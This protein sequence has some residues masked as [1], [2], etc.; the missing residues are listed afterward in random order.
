MGGGQESRVLR[1]Q[2]GQDGVL[3]ARTAGRPCAGAVRGIQADG[4]SALGAGRLAEA[5]VIQTK[6]LLCRL[7]REGLMQRHAW[8]DHCAAPTRMRH[9]LPLQLGVGSLEIVDASRDLRR[10]AHP[11][12]SPAQAMVV[13]LEVGPNDEVS[14]VKTYFGITFRSR[15]VVL[16]TGTFMNGTI[17]VGR[18]SM[19]AGRCDTSPHWL[20]S[21]CKPSGCITARWERSDP[22]EGVEVWCLGSRGVV[23]GVVLRP[24]IG[25]GAAGAE[26]HDS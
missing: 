8:P 4:G 20:R 18:Q 2:G 19:S 12:L 5:S 26:Q 14:G 7:G 17:W 3:E 10:R 6:P 13:G 11:G 16:T 25:L 15:A 21:C 23:L 9:T 24:G 1:K 22:A